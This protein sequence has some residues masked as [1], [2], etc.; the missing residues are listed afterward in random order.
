MVQG[1]CGLICDDFLSNFQVE[2]SEG[3]FCKE[4]PLK[5]AQ[6]FVDNSS[7]AGTSGV[8]GERVD[9]NSKG[10]S[11]DDSKGEMIAVR[12]SSIDEEKLGFGI[13][14]V[15]ELIVVSS[16]DGTTGT[17][18]T[19]A[20]SSS[21]T[22][23]TTSLTGHVTRVDNSKTAVVTLSSKE[24]HTLGGIERVC[25]SAVQ[26]RVTVKKTK[27][28]AVIDHHPLDAQLLSPT[29]SH[30]S[31]S[32]SSSSSSSSS[33][34]TSTSSSSST[35]T[36]TTPP[37]PTTIHFAACNGCLSDKKDRALSMCLLAA[38]RALE[39]TTQQPPPTQQPPTTSFL[40]ICFFVFCFF[41]SCLFSCF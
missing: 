39:G 35:T 24:V 32:L 25:A 19:G 40:F 10:S 16:T 14:D 6:L 31:T 9:D 2:D 11:K 13:G 29:A 1:V 21:G 30:I 18:G 33:S 41:K 8:K 22:G 15:V 38:F 36:A 3:E 7:T 26:G 34:S 20:G 12:I 28:P 27:Q 17:G 5:D 37:P 23:S 4:I